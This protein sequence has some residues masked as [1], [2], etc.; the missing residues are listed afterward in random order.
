MAGL[1][2]PTEE[3]EIHRTPRFLKF[4]IFDKLHTVIMEGKRKI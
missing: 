3:L 4:S 2:S 1:K